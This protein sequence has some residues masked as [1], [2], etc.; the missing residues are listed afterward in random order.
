MTASPETITLSASLN[1]DECARL[2]AEITRLQ[3]TPVQVD[4]SE[5]RQATARCL[6]LLL[7]AK[8]QWERNALSFEIMNPSE[9]FSSAVDNLDLSLH[10]YSERNAA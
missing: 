10:L 8:R 9:K 5:V 4:A 6:Q 7:I 3:G 1:H 2:A